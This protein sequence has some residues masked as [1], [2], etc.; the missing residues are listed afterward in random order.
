MEKNGYFRNLENKV[1]LLGSFKDNYISKHLSIYIIEL[2]QFL[3]LF[4][5]FILKYVFFTRAV[6]KQHPLSKR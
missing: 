6:Q 3:V 1:L 4:I 5:R 2:N